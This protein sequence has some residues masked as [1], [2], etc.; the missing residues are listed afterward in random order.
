MGNTANLVL[1]YPEDTDP[2][3]NMA[4]AV[5]ALATALDGY[6]YRTQRF[7]VAVT[8][9]AGSIAVSK[10]IVFPIAFP[11]GTVP[12]VLT[13][14][15]TVAVAP[16]YYAGAYSVTNTGCSVRA[17]KLVGAAP[18]APVNLLIAVMLATSQAT[19]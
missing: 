1:P 8:M 12:V 6:L 17:D 2:L 5:E 9:P 13:S 15:A 10:V 11:V 18:G 14:V 16:G 19:L 3:A 7:Y 4:A